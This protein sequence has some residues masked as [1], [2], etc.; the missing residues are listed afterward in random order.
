[1]T[2]FRLN[3]LW[4]RCYLIL[5]ILLSGCTVGPNYHRPVDTMPEKYSS[6][7]QV[8]SYKQFNQFW[9]R[10]FN[11]PVLIGLIN[12]ALKG[13]NLDI[14]KAYANI[15]QARA[16]LNIANADYYP[17]IDAN[18]RYVRDHLSG[19]SEIISAFPQGIIP[20]TYTDAKFGFD[21]SWEIDLFGHTRREVEASRARFQS[22]IENQYNVA[23]ATSAEVA[24]IYTQYRVYQQR[25]LIAKHTVVSYTETAKLVQLQQQAGVA[26]G[27]DLQ[28]VESEVLSA[29]STLPPLQ[30]EA[31][32]SL[33]ALAVLVGELPEILF[34]EL[35]ETAPIP[36]MKQKKLSLGLPSDLLQRRPDI[37]MAERNLAAA[38]AD[39]GVAVANQFPRIQLIGDLGFDTT[40]PGTYLQAA[41]RYWTL[42]PQILSMPIFQGGR[43]KN[44]VKAQKAAADIAL[45][46]YKQ[47][48]LQALADV[49]SSLIRYERERL[50]RQKWLASYNKL[51]SAR[52]LIQLQYREGQTTLLDVLDVERQLDQLNDQYVQSVGQVTTNLISFYK[53][54]GGSWIT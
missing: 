41:S 45:A 3:F 31:K 15:R 44:A 8:F 7:R 48:I 34:H 4:H 10:A 24:R 30:A 1:M 25:I 17:Q 51:K 29:K 12:Q 46:T 2:F 53:A 23:L 11:D 43:L 6:T 40:K 22:A 47:A 35:S 50:A 52:R 33:A 39:I 20:L 14:Q 27:V 19:N 28:R 36:L 16:E 26:T 42:G 32:A 18:G 5:I 49:E 54:L 38:T 9:W 21:A 37:R 13:A